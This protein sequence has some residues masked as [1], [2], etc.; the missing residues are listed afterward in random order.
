MTASQNELI[1]MQEETNRIVE[2]IESQRLDAQSTASFIYALFAVVAISMI[3]ENFVRGYREEKRNKKQAGESV[4][5]IRVKL[6]A[7][8][9]IHIVVIIILWAVCKFLLN[10]TIPYIGFLIAITV[11]IVEIGP[12]FAI[13][14]KFKK[15]KEKE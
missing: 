2:S 8:Y 4:K 7:T 1:Q 3:F 11:Y 15:D 12:L 6:L 13:H 10:L 14:L 9:G 5:D